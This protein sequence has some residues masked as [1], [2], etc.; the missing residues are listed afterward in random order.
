MSLSQAQRNRRILAQEE[1]LRLDPDWDSVRGYRQT[2]RKKTKEADDFDDE[3][4]LELS[5]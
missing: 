5:D 3:K 4:R 1:I 2:G